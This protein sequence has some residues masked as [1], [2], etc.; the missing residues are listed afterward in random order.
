M[1]LTRIP[2]V[3]NIDIAYRTIRSAIP[4]MDSFQFEASG[5]LTRTANE[6]SA[7]SRQSLPQRILNPD[8]IL[9]ALYVIFATMPIILRVVMYYRNVSAPDR[10][11]SW[12]PFFPLPGAL[13]RLIQCIHHASVPVHYMLFPPTVPERKDLL[14][15]APDGLNRP[16]TTQPMV[17]AERGKKLLLQQEKQQQQQ[18][19]PTPP[20]DNTPQWYDVLDLLIIFF[21]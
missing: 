12:P 16:K 6:R 5:S 11:G 2:G 1:P 9:H 3:L 7:T 10:A 4:G 14:V 21:C 13:I 17:L 19:K 18:Q 20:A 8:I 15:K